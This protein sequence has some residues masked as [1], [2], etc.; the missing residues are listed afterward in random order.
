MSF[1]DEGDEPR[2]VIRSP[3]PQPRRPPGRPRRSPTDDRTLL[4]RR[5]GAAAIALIV[6]IGLV[7][8]IKAILDHQ[9]IQGLKDYNNKVSQLVHAEQTNVRNPFFRETV[10]AY[11]SPNPTEVPTTLQ[12]WVQ[13]E[14]IYYNDAQSWSVPAQMVGAQR[15]FVQALGFRYEALQRI[16]ATMSSVLGVSNDQGAQITALAGDMEMLLTSDGIYAERVAPLITEAL[17]KAGI[18]GQT[19]PSST[20]LPD[21]AWIE[22]QTVAQR[23]LG[24]VPTSLGGAPSTGS[25]G[26]ELLS[27]SIRGPS[28]TPTVLQSGTSTVSSYPY[29]SAGFTFILTIRNS[30]TGDVHGVMP[31]IYIHKTGLN[32]SCLTTPA[33]AIAVTHPGGTYTA[34]IVFA[35][36][37]S[38]LSPFYNQALLMTAEVKPLPGETD[39]SNNRQHILIE[40]TH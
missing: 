10:N 35:P 3:K 31:R 34:S 22:P 6:A 9:A 30:G 39:T 38:C 36:A 7:L 5:G 16:A 20:F 4:V 13:Q 14:R 15:Q 8:G 29:T 28:G 17:A 2:T 24:Y 19:T 18:T 40:F 21:I 11:N 32:T 25:N 27:V 26:H 1:F 37:P 23:I 12:Q 33:P